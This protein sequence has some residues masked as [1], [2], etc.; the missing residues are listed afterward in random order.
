M[1]CLE[2]VLLVWGR[3][4]TASEGGRCPDVARCEE[5]YEAWF[6][7]RIAFN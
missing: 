5:A 4:R 6:E 2:E 7:S 1:A 3:A